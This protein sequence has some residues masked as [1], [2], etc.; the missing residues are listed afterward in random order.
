PCQAAAQALPVQARRPVFGPVAGDS[1]GQAPA[2]A[3][4]AGG[5]AERLEIHAA[6]AAPDPHRSLRPVFKP[7]RTR[8]ASWT[9]TSLVKLKVRLHDMKCPRKH[10]LTVRQSGPRF[11]LGCENYPACEYTEP[12]SILDEM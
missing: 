10:P 2:D 4:H 5:P 8:P 9:A 1:D 7:A 11:F 12:L 6:L 3:G